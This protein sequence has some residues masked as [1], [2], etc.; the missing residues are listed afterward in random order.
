MRYI[1]ICLFL[2]VFALNTSAQIITTVAGNGTAG[3]SGDGGQATAAEIN[4]PYAVTFDA[5]GNLYIVDNYNNRVRKVN[6]SGIIST[7]VGNGTA[8]YIGD[9]GQATAAEIKNSA[10]IALDAAGNVYIADAGNNCIRKVNTAGIISTIAGNGISGFSGDGGQATAAELSLPTAVA[11]D[12]HGNFYISDDYNQRIRI[13][14]TAGIINTFAGN[15]T[16]GFGGDGGQATAAELF[17]P[18][19]LTL[20]AVDNLYIADSQNQRIRK[21]NTLGI[22]ST[23]AGNGIQGYSGDGGIATAAELKY[24]NGV[25]IDGTGNIYIAD[26]VNNRI[27]KVNTAGIISTL[28]GNGTAGFSGDCGNA[29]TAELSD[30]NIVVVDASGNLYIADYANNRI[31]MISNTSCVAAG[32]E[33]LININEQVTI[34]PNP[35]TNSLQVSFYS[36]HENTELKVVNMLGE[37]VIEPV[38]YHSQ[39]F[40]V[41]VS[42]LA[43][44]VYI[45]ELS[46]SS[47]KSVKR[48][49]KE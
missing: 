26:D 27:R 21:V 47:G 34:Y 12:T 18:I 4:K 13:V 2:S 24:P 40:T 44:G 10:G 8:G 7:I 36:S 3:Y 43:T 16:N 22:I 28:A 19:G 39:N 38:T 23:I 1:Y 41:D 6:T 30:P 46:Y 37:V 5:E 45:L 15:G 32:I 14:N 31:R 29:I 25:A 20:D 11:I 49:I 35:A 42:Q 9:G 48:L 33:Q 17:Y